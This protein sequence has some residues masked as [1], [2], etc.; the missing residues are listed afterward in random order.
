MMTKILLISDELTRISLL[1]EL[2]VV[3]V[4]R[5][6]FSP[7]VLSKKI[8]F[9]LVESAW[10]GYKNSWKYKIA[11]YPDVS[12]RN[13]KA[14]VDLVVRAKDA[15]IP[16][17]FWNKEDSVHF[18]RFIDS[19]KWFDHILTVDEN[20]VERYRKVVP[21]TTTVN[22]GM[23]CVQ[24]RIHNFQGFRFKNFGANFIGSYSS[25][26][27]DVRRS[28][29]ELLFLAAQKAG[30]SVTIFD[31]NSERKSERYRYPENQFNLKML[32]AVTYERTADLYRDYLVS[33]NVNTIEDSPTMYSRRVVEV[34]ACAGI[35]VSTPGLAVERLFGDY[36]H[37]VHD[38]DGAVDLF[39]RLKS[40]PSK[41]DIE[42]AR[43]GC[44]FVLNHFTWR[45]FLENIQAIINRK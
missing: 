13:N 17:V 4:K 18:D 16:T 45:H 30:L 23:F 37:V 39:D 44:D 34:L 6:I 42:K 21:S 19:A 36:C 43:A 15:G 28:R 27:H 32:P 8:N 3:S 31:R 26:T 41:Q 1:P 9:I 7:I 38:L 33:L 12:S 24:P 14:L 11:S 40:G 22:V 29:Q 2:D 20:C 25:H 5:N 35:L 10:S